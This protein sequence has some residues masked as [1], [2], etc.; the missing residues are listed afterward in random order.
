MLQ[1]NST[2]LE[3]PNSLRQN[4]ILTTQHYLSMAPSYDGKDPKQFHNWLDE[5]VRL[6][7]QYNLAY[8][9]VALTTSR[10]SVHRYVKELISKNLVCPLIKIKLCKRFSEWTNTATAQNGFSCLKEDDNS[11]HEY[12]MKFTDLLEH[13]YGVRPSDPS[14]KLLANQFIE[15]MNDS[16]KYTEN[17]LREKGHNHL[18]YYFKEA[19]ALQCKQEISSINFGQQSFTNITECSDIQALCTNSGTFQGCCSPDHFI[20]DCLTSKPGIG[21]L[22]LM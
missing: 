7:H 17:K 2:Q 10:G 3:L 22:S 4:A 9:E 20:K 21:N 13:A 12:I 15:G 16:N 14:T 18:D 19:V 1:L 8:T 11:I 6:A 5:V